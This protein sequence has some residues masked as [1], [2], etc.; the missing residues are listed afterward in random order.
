MKVQG[1]DS[2]A[3]T[4]EIQKARIEDNFRLGSRL[5][6]MSQNAEDQLNVSSEGRDMQILTDKL[7]NQTLQLPEVREDR[8]ADVQAKLAS[9]FYQSDEFDASLAERLMEDP[10]LS[11][12]LDIP[13]LALPSTDYREDLM[14]DV[15]GKINDSFYSDNEVMDYVAERL[16]SIY[17]GHLREPGA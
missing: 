6:A 17:S 10:D 4:R 5:N 9:G 12:V 15:Q 2:V 14:Q 7:A 8:L 11:Q 16:M 3:I 1:T 13:N